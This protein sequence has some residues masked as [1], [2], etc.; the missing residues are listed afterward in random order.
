[1]KNSSDTIGNRTR[2]LPACRTAPQPTAPP[3]ACPIALYCWDKNMYAKRKF[4]CSEYLN[5][6]FLE[7]IWLNKEITQILVDST[8]WVKIKRY[9]PAISLVSKNQLGK[10]GNYYCSH[11]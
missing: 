7:E 8:V 6:N 4:F 2:D 10:A 9:Y 11:W 3:V 5:I 1:M